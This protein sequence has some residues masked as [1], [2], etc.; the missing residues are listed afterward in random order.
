MKLALCLLGYDVL[1]EEVEEQG[2]VLV[3]GRLQIQGYSVLVVHCYYY[4][5]R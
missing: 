1:P 3:E 4:H 5:H 2:K